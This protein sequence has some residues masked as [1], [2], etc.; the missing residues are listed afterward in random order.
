MRQSLLCIIFCFASIL[1]SSGQSRVGAYAQ[2]ML[3]KASPEKTT[4]D[5]FVRG[6]LSAVKKA[7]LAAGGTYKYGSGKYSSVT[8][9]LKRLESFLS[10]PAISVQNAEVKM[11]PLLDTALIV[12]CVLPVH[13]GDAPL[14]QPYKGDG[15]IMGVIDYG[16]DFTHD[17][18]KKPNGDTRIRYIWDQNVA[19]VNSPLP[20]NYG[21]EWNEFEINAG[22]CSHYE[23]PYQTAGHG[24]TVAGIAAGDGSACSG[25]NVGVAPN[26]ELIVVAINYQSAF[27]SHFADAVDY[28]FKKADAMGK[29]CVINGSFGA[30]CG[31]HDGKD[32]A[33]HLIDALLEERPGRALVCAN[34]NAGAL[35]YHLGYEVTADTSF[36]W[37]KY[38]QAHN[39]LFF[40][41]WADTQDFNDV[42]FAIGTDDPSTWKNVGRSDFLNILHDYTF[43]VS[44]GDTI[45]SRNF[46]QVDTN[47]NYLGAVSTTIWLTEGRYNINVQI[48]GP[49]PTSHYW[50][51]ITTGSG[52]F[53]GWNTSL[54]GIEQSDMVTDLP[55]PGI[56]PDI[57]HY[58]LPDLNST[59]VTSFTCSDKVIAVGNFVNRGSYYDIDSNRVSTG[60]I[61][62]LIG[63]SSSRGPTR[64]G[65]IKPDISATGDFTLAAGHLGQIAI[66]SGNADRYKVGYCGQYFRNGGTSMASPV[67]AGVAALYL[68]MH[69]NA[70]WYEVKQAILTSAKADSF[71]GVVPNNTYGYGKVQACGAMLVGFGCT[72]STAVNYD[73]TATMDDGSCIIYG[74]TDSLAENYNPKATHD[75]GSCIKYGCTDSTALNYDSTAT[76]DDGT[77]IERVY[78]CTD[79]TAL[80]YNPNANTDN[81][82]CYY[83]GIRSIPNAEGIKLAFI[84][85]FFRSECRIVYEFKKPL[86]GKVSLVIT[87]LLGQQVDE[88][89]LNDSKGEIIYHLPVNASGVFFYHLMNE[90]KPLLSGKVVVY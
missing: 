48:N 35:P 5:L 17:D 47:G 50:S 34:G 58:K 44:G 75:D 55:P 77:C 54:L 21:R 27:L 59:M 52:K 81:G 15:V 57:V 70:D 20:Y 11:L 1:P 31:S 73:S 10:T 33:A 4:I 74:C 86:N 82:T 6:E 49:V 53:D 37:F 26:S 7:V 68:Q 76:V 12:N 63:G 22:Q 64:D 62:G 89:T 72:D 79:S 25:R 14:S 67:V 40:D 42:Y 36:T 90:N 87:N 71:T 28:I 24:T 13:H 23:N 3:K 60:A 61:P 80:N 84:P 78:G 39:D 46:D 9:P 69:P 56:R 43:Y 38:N 8:V 85:N 29:P 41:F 83:V 66:S 32:F 45:A 2:R 19:S 88:M 18:F 51:F 30:Y 65:R 16:I